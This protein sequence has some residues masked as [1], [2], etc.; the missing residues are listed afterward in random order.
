VLAIVN[1][2]FGAASPSLARSLT[3]AARDAWHE[4]GRGGEAALL[5]EQ[6]NV[7]EARLIPGPN[8]VPNVWNEV[9]CS[10]LRTTL[11]AA[12]NRSRVVPLTKGA[13]CVVV[14]GI[15]LAALLANAKV[16]HVVRLSAP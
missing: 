9:F 3:V 13:A 11:P 2:P 10:W 8:L 14:L 1:D 7:G 12:T 15:F 5:A 4:V 6:R 16:L